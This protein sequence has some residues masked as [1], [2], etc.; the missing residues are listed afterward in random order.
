LPG[1]TTVSLYNKHFCA[2]PTSATEKW[3]TWSSSKIFAMANA[4]GHLRKDETACQSSVFG[5]HDYTT[6]KL[7][8]TPLADLATIVCSYD[9]TAGYSSNSLSSYFHDLVVMLLNCKLNLHVL[10]SSKRIS[11]NE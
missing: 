3:E 11:H 1:E 8:K 2:G 9:H 6:G 4:A 10:N 5:L 7:G